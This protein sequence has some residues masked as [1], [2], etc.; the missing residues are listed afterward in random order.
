MKK[1][2][3]ALMCGVAVAAWTAPAIAGSCEGCEV[4]KEHGFGFCD[5]CNKGKIYG[6]ELTSKNLYDAL[7]GEEGVAEDLKKSECKGCRAAAENNGSCDHCGVHVAHSKVY[8]SKTAHTLAMGIPM[9]DPKVAK[10]IEKCSG[11]ASAAKNHK[12]CSACNVG[13]VGE[14][15]YKS[16]ESH[17]AAL[18]AHE[19]LK[20]AIKDT[21]HCDRCAVARVTDG[22]CAHC[23]VHFKGGKPVS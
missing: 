11:C 20:A 5:H 3:M 8:M 18:A 1:A 22:K 15:A 23:N 7:T 4:I 16:K 12:F 21:G 14:S 6:L 13:F 19:V 9:S 10:G 2:L 17:D